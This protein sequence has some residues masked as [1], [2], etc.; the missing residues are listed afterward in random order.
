[1]PT[2][3]DIYKPEWIDEDKKKDTPNN[4]EAKRFC[5]NF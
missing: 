1:M 2:D 3:Y 5:S 4:S